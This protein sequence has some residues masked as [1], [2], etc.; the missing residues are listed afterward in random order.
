MAGICGRLALP[1]CLFAAA[2]STA[3]ADLSGTITSAQES[4]MEGVIVTAR[5]QGSSISHT[6][7]TQKDGSFTFPSKLLVKGT[8]HLSVRATGYQLESNVQ[9]EW[10]DTPLRITIK[11]SPNPAL[12]AQLTNAEWLASMP[13]S[14]NDKKQL[15]GCTNCHT[16]QRIVESKYT[17]SEFLDVMGRMAQYSNNSFPLHPQI[18]VAETNAGVRFGAGTDKFAEF[19]ASINLSSVETWRYDLKTLPRIKGAGTRVMITEF[20]LPKET[21]MA[22]DVVVHQDGKIYFSDFGANQIGELDPVSGKVLEHPYPVLRPDYPKGGLDLEQ[23]ESGN[24]W[25]AMMYQG[26]IL[27][28]DPKTKEVKT[29]PVPKELMNEATQQALIAPHHQEVD[30]KVWVTNVGLNKIH[31]VDVKT[32]AYETIDP[33]KDMPKGERHSAYGMN[34]DK[35]NNLWFNDFSAEAIVKIDAKTLAVSVFKT[36]TAKSRPRRGHM[37]ENDRLAFAEFYGDR[38]GILDTKTGKMTEYAVPTQHSAPYDAALDRHGFLWTAGMETDRIIRINTQTA[39]TT[40]YPLPRQT[41]IRRIFVDDSTKPSIVWIGNNEGASIIK[42][43][44]LD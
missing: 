29:Y 22:H 39:E 31:R 11:L 26:G 42:L 18:R 37:D 9:A 7:V 28:F 16:L 27:R 32:G 15:Y 21:T 34:A 17:A 3:H 1:V 4:M 5:L 40:E 19:L 24:L 33:F 10:R 44:P 23:D 30:G 8:Y 36:G 13:G 25:L 6:V 43:Q 38:A 12:A 20:D 35:Q 2:V 14:M 41:N